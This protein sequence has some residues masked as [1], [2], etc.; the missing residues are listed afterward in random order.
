MCSTLISITQYLIG[1]SL[2]ALITIPIKN[3]S[4]SESFPPQNS[5]LISLLLISGIDAC[6]VRYE[7]ENAHGPTS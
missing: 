5:R 4:S 1:W 2:S 7:E 3:I 6:L